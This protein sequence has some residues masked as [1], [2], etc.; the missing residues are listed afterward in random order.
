MSRWDS[1]AIVSKTS[2]LLPDPE[3][4]VNTVNRRF[5]ISTLTSL[6]LFSRAPSTRIRSWLSATRGACGGA[7]GRASDLVAV[8]IVLPSV[9]SCRCLLVGVASAVRVG[10]APARSDRLARRPLHEL[11][12]PRLF[13]GAQLLQREGDRPHGAL[14]EV[15]RVAEA[16]RRVPRVE[17]LGALEVADDLAVLV[18]VGGHPVPGLRREGG[19][20]GLD[21]LVEPLGHRAIRFGH[22]GDLGEQVA[23]PF[24]LLLVRAR[25]RLQL[26]GALPHGGP[27]LGREPLGVLRAHRY[28]PCGMFRV[29]FRPTTRVYSRLRA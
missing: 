10:G 14:V 18:G 6:R 19:R 29:L 20:A 3:T 11:A 21:D 17:L 28:L 7:C 22:L 15:R 8:L 24:S 23:L 5:G 9:S 25:F 26:L 16:E 27:F 13:G 1:A 4:P 2:E 12:D